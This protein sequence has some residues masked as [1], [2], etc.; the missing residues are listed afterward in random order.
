MQKHLEKFTAIITRNKKVFVLALPLVILFSVFPPTPAEAIAPLIIWGGVALASWLFG[1]PGISGI[2][3]SAA[4]PLLEA[5][6]FFINVVI[7]TITSIVQGFYI[8]VGEVLHTVITYFITIPIN[9][10]FVQEAFDF[11]RGFVN[12]LFILIL[13][14]IG[15]AT[16]LRM[17]SYQFQRTLP[18]LIIIALLVNFSG[19]LVGFIADIGNILTNIFLNASEHAAYSTNPWG[20]SPVDAAK[21]SQNIARILFF[22]IGSLIYFIVMLLFGVRV[23]IL[24][25]LTILAPLAFAALILPATKSYWTKWWSA[26][27]QWSIV[28]IPISFFLFLAGSAMSWNPPVA[29]GISQTIFAVFAPLTALVL[30]FI[31]ITLSMQM[32]PAGAQG[33]INIAKQAG[34]RTAGWAARE[35]WRKI[36]KRTEKG[37]GSVRKKGQDIAANAEERLKTAK[38]GSAQWVGSHLARFGGKALSVAGGGVEMGSQKGNLAVSKR[39]QETI[40]KAEKG[41]T[42]EHFNRIDVQRAKAAAQGGLLEDTSQELGDFTG[43]IKNGDT[44]D[45]EDRI[46]DG[47]MSWDFVRKMYKNAKDNGNV[48][49]RRLIEKAFLSRT[50]DKKDAQGNI[51]ENSNELGVDSKDREKVLEKLDGADFKG[52]IGAESLDTTTES[53]R[54]VWD[55]IIKHRGADLM[56]QFLRNANKEQRQAASQ[57]L[58]DKEL[59]WYID[60][61]A[62]DVLKYSISPAAASLGINPIGGITQDQLTELVATKKPTEQI[63]REMGGIDIQL[64]DIETALLKKPVGT[65]L[66]QLNDKKKAL[67]KRKKEIETQLALRAGFGPE[68]AKDDNTQIQAKRSEYN[69]TVQN[70]QALETA[71]PAASRNGDYYIR[72]AT[73]IKKR[74]EIAS[75]F[76]R[77]GLKMEE[78][79][80]TPLGDQPLSVQI[81]QLKEQEEQLKQ[82]AGT[83]KRVL[84]VGIPLTGEA[85]VSYLPGEK[86]RAKIREIRTQIK[87]LEK[88]GGVL[89]TDISILTQDEIEQYR[90]E[91]ME[92]LGKIDSELA[93]VVDKRILAAPA[94]PERAEL[95]R[96][97]EELKETRNDTMRTQ[98]QLIE[99]YLIKTRGDLAGAQKTKQLIEQQ[100]KQIQERKRGVAKGSTE[101]R[102]VVA[103]EQRVEVLRRQAKTRVDDLSAQERTQQDLWKPFYDFERQ[104][105]PELD[106]AKE[107]AGARTAA[108]E[109]QKKATQLRTAKATAEAI[110]E[111]TK[112]LETKKQRQ[113][114]LERMLVARLKQRESENTIAFIRSVP[115]APT[116]DDAVVQFLEREI[117]EIQEKEKLFEIDT[118]PLPQPEQ[119]RIEQE[120]AT[121]LK[122]IEISKKRLEK[123]MDQLIKQ[124]KKTV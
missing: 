44:K 83:Q 23:I 80:A 102:A 49:Q 8:A 110:T 16:I 112:N 6:A 95:M 62:E 20:G 42:Q 123:T 45:I 92:K 46:K 124:E 21:I 26:L 53:G 38:F 9:Q 82:T 119:E 73:L 61:G 52:V 66:R 54:M 113:E 34:T 32:A 28:G 93:D 18:L 47:R 19:V 1:V 74:D 65:L 10:P 88:R 43:I 17:Q 11:T 29:Q 90:L 87:E 67:T 22:V 114:V 86:A 84:G 30:L 48:D 68:D 101:E 37:A 24:W 4:E 40:D 94:S 50:F 116:S 33:V 59:Q 57:Y 104:G 58:N 69:T 7:A 99:A 85:G 98:R 81:A 122:E 120:K 96:R 39:D 14:F 121:Y 109:A 13:V 60:N 27:I 71:T 72:E 56:P 51:I 106:L 5:L 76:K 12:M 79:A 118:T 100:L 63:K 111:A 91:N 55:E 89:P 75:E 41:T 2:V 117:Q 35:S 78:A 64:Q 31:G 70:L 15:L 3:S 105:Q 25:A 97:E 103:E 115:A 108:K 107:L 77:R 36:G